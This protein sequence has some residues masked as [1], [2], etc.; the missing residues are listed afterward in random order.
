MFKT[1][2]NSLLA[3]LLPLCA[4]LTI[5]TAIAMEPETTKRIAAKSLVKRSQQKKKSDFSFT[6][7]SSEETSCENVGNEFSS[8]EISPL[9]Y[10]F[11][12]QPKSFSLAEYNN[13]SGS[14]LP[15]YTG[16]KGK[17]YVILTREARGK[18]KRKYDDF[19]GGREKTDKHPKI[20]AAREFHEEGILQ[21]TL[22][23]NLKDTIRFL[24]S[25]NSNTITVIAYSKDKNP[26]RPNSRDVRN[27]TY[28]VDF[29]KYADQLLHNFYGALTAEKKYNRENHI[30]RHHQHTT[31]KD[32]IASVLYDDLK[33]AVIQNTNSKAVRVQANVLNPRTD[34]FYKEQITLRPFLVEKLRPYFLDMQYDQGEDKK[35][36]HYTI[37]RQ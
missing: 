36:R 37:F 11:K 3:R 27:V 22:N 28:I 34:K 8:E 9:S 16:P 17:R 19:S 20:S 32:K 21:R 10:L 5:V 25:K 23:W 31:E 1:I 12:A 13:R 26:E 14:V 33:E 29:D 18:E 35:I 6:E 7:S 24:N 2:K 30:P 4:M 15:I